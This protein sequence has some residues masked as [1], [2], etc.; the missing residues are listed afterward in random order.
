MPGKPKVIAVCLLVCF[1]SLAFSLEEAGV[2]GGSKSQLRPQT[3][4]MKELC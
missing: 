3:M 1:N 4:E 2:E